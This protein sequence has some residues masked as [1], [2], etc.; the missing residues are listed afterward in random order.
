V[1]AHDTPETRVRAH[2]AGSFGLLVKPFDKRALFSA[3]EI[4]VRS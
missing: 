1:T 3:I 2:Q 4:A